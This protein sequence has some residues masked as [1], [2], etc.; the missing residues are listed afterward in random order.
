MLIGGPS[1]GPVIFHPQ[2]TKIS[3][4]MNDLLGRLNYYGIQ[5]SK[6][7]SNPDFKVTLL[8]GINKNEYA[9]LDTSGYSHLTVLRI[10][11]PTNNFIAFAKKSRQFLKCYSIHP[12]ILISGDLVIG[13]LAALLFQSLSRSTLPIQVSIHGLLINNGH[14]E[15]QKLRRIVQKLLLRIFLPKVQSVRV[16]SN[17]LV[18]PLALDY[19]LDQ[20]KFLVAP[21]PFEKYP[22]FSIRDFSSISLGIVGRLH[23]E[24]NL[25]ESLKIVENVLDISTISKIYIIG[26]GPL[27]GL[28]Q[29]WKLG[30]IHA[31][32]VEILGSIAHSESIDRLQEI[33][34]LISSAHSEGYGLA[35]RE[36]L[37]SGSVVIARNNEGTREVLR[38]FGRGIFLYDE[39]SEAIS[40]IQDLASGKLAPSICYDGIKIQQKIDVESLRSLATSWGQD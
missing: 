31:D 14:S 19:K 39:V 2:V 17:F 18:S 20:K 28:L 35:I 29:S 10:M 8:V 9:D 15:V 23:P 26:D 21:I 36:A 34:I 1:Q 6:A 27:R 5:I 4:E 30:M 24:R 13:L 40:I 38:D 12:N 11:N 25:T 37:I 33:H 16:V 3:T 22:E 32:K 7:I